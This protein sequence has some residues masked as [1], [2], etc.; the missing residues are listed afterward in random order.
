MCQKEEATTAL[1]HDNDDDGSIHRHR[2]EGLGKLP[3]TPIHVVNKT[4]SKSSHQHQ[5][6]HDSKCVDCNIWSPSLQ[7]R[8]RNSVVEEWKSQLR[9]SS[10]PS[11]AAPNAANNRQHQDTTRHSFSSRKSSSTSTSVRDNNNHPQRKASTLDRNFRKDS[12]KQTRKDSDLGSMSVDSEARREHKNVK[13]VD[14][15]WKASLS[16]CCTY[17]RRSPSIVRKTQEHSAAEHQK[18]NQRHQDETTHKS[19]KHIGSLHSKPTTASNNAESSSRRKSSAVIDTSA[20]HNKSATQKPADR[21]DSSSAHQDTRRPSKPV[22]A[23]DQAKPAAATATRMHPTAEAANRDHQLTPASVITQ[24]SDSTSTLHYTTSTQ[25]QATSTAG[26]LRLLEP[27]VAQ[28]VLQN[29][30]NSTASERHLETDKKQVYPRKAS[31]ALSETSQT[32]EHQQEII[33]NNSSQSD[34]KLVSDSFAEIKTSFEEEHTREN[35]EEIP[36]YPSVES[37]EISGSLTKSKNSSSVKTTRTSISEKAARWMGVQNNTKSATESKETQ[38]TFE[39][40][41]KKPAEQSGPKNVKQF[42]T[43]G[44]RTSFETSENKPKEDSIQTQH[45]RA[46]SAVQEDKKASKSVEQISAEKSSKSKKEHTISSSANSSSQMESSKS[47][48]SNLVTKNSESNVNN[49]SKISKTVPKKPSKPESAS[50]TTTD[51]DIKEKQTSVDSGKLKKKKMNVIT[52]LIKSTVETVSRIGSKKDTKGSI[53]HHKTSKDIYSD[54]SD[55]DGFDLISKSVQLEAPKIPS[56]KVRKPSSG[57]KPTNIP[58]TAVSQKKSISKQDQHQESGN[59]FQ[60]DSE[61]RSSSRK[62]ST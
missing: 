42:R 14:E 27:E 50:I 54:G 16:C 33:I 9:A 1:H 60:K 4:D 44:R 56:Q 38:H 11:S 6:V 41:E 40:S 28:A 61:Q 20:H 24:T 59:S 10:P 12:S 2:D 23:S 47:E 30:R 17:S 25:T 35:P 62:S 36:S 19:F 7:A 34:Q 48:N 29:R 26:A 37:P 46:S 8:N 32:S 31:L 13:Q 52:S 21:K 18:E 5:H 53:V 55:T 51:T 43:P 39:T 49:S 57:P 15:D 3:E 22:S 58:S 45:R